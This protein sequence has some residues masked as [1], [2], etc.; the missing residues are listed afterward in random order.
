MSWWEIRESIPYRQPFSSY[1]GSKVKKVSLSKS[2]G[3]AETN[4]FSI[5]NQKGADKILADVRHI[6]NRCRL[7]G[8]QRVKIAIFKIDPNRPKFYFSYTK[9]K[10]SWKEIRGR[11]SYRQPLSSYRGSKVKQVTFW[12]SLQIAQSYTF[13][14]LNEKRADKGFVDAWPIV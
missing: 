2:L 7:T 14:I 11:T 1:R 10:M 12:R 4:N 6:V 9:S 3:I 13:P 8:G 5:L